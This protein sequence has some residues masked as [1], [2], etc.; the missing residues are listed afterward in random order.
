MLF[1]GQPLG[2]PSTMGT[3]QASCSIF[4]GKMSLNMLQP[5]LQLAEHTIKPSASHKFLGVYLNQ[6]LHFKEHTNY[7][8]G[9]G[10][11]YAAQ[12]RRL[13]QGRK[14]VP[15]YI[16]TKLYQSVTLKKTLYTAEIWC[17][18]ILDPLPGKKQKGGSTGFAT[19]LACIQHTSTLFITGAIHT[20][21]P[22][23]RP[24]CTRQYPPNAP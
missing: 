14:G 17:S 11:R 5:V 10:E 9:K 23:S 8:L 22:N 24:Q 19:K 16:A 20:H 7:A 18:P 21:N 15:S 2:G 4:N 6:A 13:I 12:V 1:V 3:C